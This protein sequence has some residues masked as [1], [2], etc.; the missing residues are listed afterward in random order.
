MYRD[1]FRF[2]FVRRP[3]DRIVSAW[4]DKVLRHNFFQMTEEQ[5]IAAQNLDGFLDW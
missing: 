1:W 2:T 5:W 4:K 3:D